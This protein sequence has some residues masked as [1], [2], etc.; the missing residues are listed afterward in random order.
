MKH[1]GL[2]HVA[3]AV[4]DVRRSL[5]FY[6]RVLGVVPV[7]EEEDSIQAQTPGT[8]DVLVFERD[9]RRAGK[10]GGVVHF[11]F[12]LAKPVPLASIVKRVRNAGGKVLRKGEFAPGLPY[13]FFEDPDGYEV[14]VWYETPTA[15]EPKPGR[16]GG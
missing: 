13:V 5:D 6:Q 11:G 12:R 9:S 2:T 8:H 4:K 16:A 15:A 3:L 10:P 14:E 7:Y 1:Y